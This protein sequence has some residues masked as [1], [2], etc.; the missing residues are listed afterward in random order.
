MEASDYFIKGGIRKNEVYKGCSTFVI[1][2]GVEANEE[3][4][5]IP[6]GQ[7]YYKMVKQTCLSGACNS[8][9]LHPDDIIPGTKS[10]L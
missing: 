7:A 8:G 6:G 2:S 5:P 1:D 10:G 3:L 4:L 9:T